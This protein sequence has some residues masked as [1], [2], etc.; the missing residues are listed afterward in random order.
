VPYVPSAGPV[1]SHSRWSSSRTHCSSTV[2]KSPAAPSSIFP[3]L[4]FLISPL[5]IVECVRQPVDGV[6]VRKSA[7]CHLR[8]EYP[9]GELVGGVRVRILL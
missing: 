4:C 2:S 3:F 5:G 7:L 8:V 6:L 9:V 1:H